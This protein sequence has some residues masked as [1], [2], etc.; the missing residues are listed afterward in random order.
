MMARA[1][2]FFAAALS[3]AVPYA[4]HAQ[5]FRGPVTCDTCISDYYYVDQGSFAVQDWSCDNSSYDGH[6]GSDYSL[7]NGNFA[8]DDDN[9]VVALAAGIVEKTEDGYYDRCTQCGGAN[10]G[11]D[12]G[13]GFANQVHLDIGGYRVIYGHMK[14]GS[15]MVEPGDTVTCGQVIGYIGSAGCSTGAHLHVEPQKPVG[16]PV[17]PYEGECSPTESS[18]WVSQNAHRQ[19]PADTCDG[20]DPPPVCPADTYPIWTCDEGMT[21]RRRCIDGVDMNEPCAGGCTVMPSGTDD[22]CAM[23]PDA[24]ADGSRADVDCADSDAS[25][26]P[27][28]VEVCGDGVDQDCSGA[29]EVCP[30]AGT[31]GMSGGVGGVGAAGGTSGGL[32]GASGVGGASGGVG[33]LGGAAGML[34]GGA[35][36]GA[37]AMAGAF[38]PSGGA[39]ARSGSGGGASGCS[40]VPAPSKSG[41]GAL[42][43]VLLAALCVALARSRARSRQHERRPTLRSF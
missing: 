19:I 15:I 37:G 18:L 34:V 22:V 12:F 2:S 14:M 29:D 16:T 32:G 4:A 28:A 27:G 26:H 11:Y 42:S 6:V 25:V 35:G 1:L 36:G 23:P 30:V 33:G 3:L 10:C 7:R 38:A 9:E 41:S 31:G 20:S 13:N 17:D 39:P 43:G 8:I 24:D 21:S 40:S 5:L